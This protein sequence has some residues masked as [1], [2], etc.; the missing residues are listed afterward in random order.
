[1]NTEQQ[2]SWHRHIAF[3]PMNAH[4]QADDPTL[5]YVMQFNADERE[6]QERLS[7]KL[8]HVVDTVLAQQD[9]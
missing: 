1:M 3:D 9:R 4:S 5:T 2:L 8:A 7:Q 6:R